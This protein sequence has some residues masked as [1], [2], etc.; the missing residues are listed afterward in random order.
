LM[1]SSSRNSTRGTFVA[2]G[3][4]VVADEALEQRGAPIGRYV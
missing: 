3:E 4:G 1:A 2:V